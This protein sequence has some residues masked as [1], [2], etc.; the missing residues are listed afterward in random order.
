VAVETTL[1]AASKKAVKAARSTKKGMV[2]DL[3]F[4]VYGD[5]TGFVSWAGDGSAVL[6]GPEKAMI[7][8]ATTW[9]DLHRQA[10]R[11]LKES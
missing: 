7:W 11:Q 9:E 6:N 5:G 4:A 8:F 1:A 10:A 3:R 2:L